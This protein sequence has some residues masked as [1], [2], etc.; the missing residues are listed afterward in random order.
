MDRTHHCTRGTVKGA[1]VSINAD[2]H[3]LDERNL[4][5]SLTIIVL[6]MLD[7]SALLWRLRLEG[8]DVD[9]RFG[10]LADTWSGK[11]AGHDAFN[12]VHAAMA[13]VG[14]GRMQ[15]AE[16]LRA[17][18]PR[19]L[20]AGGDN[21]AMTLEVGLPLVEALIAFEAGR[22]AE[23]VDRILLVRGLAQRVG[24]SHAQRD[25]LT[26]TAAIR[27]GLRST[28]EALAAE[29]I[30]HKRESPWA[31]RLWRCASPGPISLAAE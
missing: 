17:D 10:R 3:A 4:L 23:T 19:S 20:E 7:A 27:G 16:K 28:A 12:E 24:G 1:N 11:T 9:D 25:V 30:T 14:A 5:N 29:R 21:R 31:R 13:M 8:V 18:M 6:E 22:S 15:K 26:L 2:P